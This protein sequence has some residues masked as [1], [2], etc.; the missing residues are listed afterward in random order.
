MLL[1]VG[2][3][4]CLAGAVLIVRLSM[5]QGRQRAQKGTARYL[6][7]TGDLAVQ[8]LVF[9]GLAAM[10]FGNIGEHMRERTLPEHP[11]LSLLGGAAILLL[12]GI[13]LGRLHMRWRVQPF[14]AEPD[15]ETEVRSGVG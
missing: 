14:M 6:E 15:T 8:L 5:R 11:W 12:L 4:M 9:G 2:I 3:F 13:Q 7:G 1:F 10:L